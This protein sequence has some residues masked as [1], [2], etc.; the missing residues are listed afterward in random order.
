MCFQNVLCIS[1]NL[2]HFADRPSRNA[3]RR[4]HCQIGGHFELETVCSSRLIL[5]ALSGHSWTHLATR[6][7]FEASLDVH[8]RVAEDLQS[9]SRDRVCPS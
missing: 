2:K 1:R 3:C 4:Y 8:A 6:A 5:I 9:R 7:T